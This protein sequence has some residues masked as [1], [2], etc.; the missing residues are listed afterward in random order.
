MT[1][2]NVP[3]LRFSEFSDEWQERVLKNVCYFVK[4]GFHGSVKDSPNGIPLLSAKDIY[5]NKVNINSNSRT[6]SES[7]YRSIFKKN[8]PQKGDVLITIVGTIGRTAVVKDDSIFAFQRSVGWLRPRLELITSSFLEKCIESQNFQKKLIAKT[9]TSAQGGVYLDALGKININIPSL[10]EQVKISKLLDSIDERIKTQ[11]KIIEKYESLIK[12]IT[13]SLINSQNVKEYRFS[14]LYDKAGEGGTPD[15]KDKSNYTN[16]H[17]PF[18]KIDD[19]KEKILISNN[20]FIT[21]KGLSNSSAWLV[22]KNSIIFSNGATIGKISINAYPVATKQGIL[23]I[24]P[25]KLVQSEYLYLFMKS[26]Y[27]RRQIKR[28][29]VTGTMSCAYLKDI[30][31]IKCYIP[32]IDEQT[33]VI[34]KINAFYSAI[35]LEKKILKISLSMKRFLLSNLFI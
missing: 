6:I 26:T 35:E 30:N 18:I 34:Q 5:D 13:E 9:N 22:P 23:S 21:E 10:K 17:I 29:T 16:G 8:I 31:S 32:E 11:K 24:V 2:P 19:L 15:T 27:F 4:D 33:Q 7:D 3:P 25:A 28:I 1:I 20:D 14:K 12:G